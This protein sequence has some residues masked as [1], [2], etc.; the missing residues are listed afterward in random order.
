MSVNIYHGFGF[1][2]D[3]FKALADLI[4][5]YPILLRESKFVFVP[6]PTDPGLDPIFPRFVD[7]IYKTTCSFHA[8]DP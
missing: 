7:H 5:E 4:S 8:Y 1:I 3:C 6:G 2:P